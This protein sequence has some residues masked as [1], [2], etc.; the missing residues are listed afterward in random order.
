MTYPQLSRTLPRHTMEWFEVVLEC[1][2]STK[3]GDFTKDIHQKSGFEANDVQD[4]SNTHPGR[5]EDPPQTPQN[6]PKTPHDAPKTIPR[7]LH[8]NF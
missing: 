6:A 4:A 7:H 3:N 8:C 1:L 5:L 2:W